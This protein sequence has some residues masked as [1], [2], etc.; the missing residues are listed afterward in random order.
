MALDGLEGYL[1][2]HLP[3]TR[4]GQ[5]VKVNVV[6]FADDF[7]ITGCTR[8]FLVTI[9]KPLVVEFLRE[10]EP[11]LSPE[12]TRVTHIEDGFDFLGQNFRKYNGKLLIKPSKKSITSLLE[13]VLGIVKNNRQAKTENLI[14]LLNPVIRG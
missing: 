3:N 9:V 10:R 1:R 6:R 8:E 12:K 4:K 14:R 5:K 11:E 2:E 7:I 13:K